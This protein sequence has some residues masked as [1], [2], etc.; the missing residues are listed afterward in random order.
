[1]K[2]LIREPLVH[3]LLLGAALFALDSALSRKAAS[4]ADEIVVSQGQ[5][6]NLTANFAKAWQRAPEPEELKTLVDEY[7][8]EEM[9]SREAIKL[10]LDRQDPV[11]RQRLQQKMEFLAED[12]SATVDPTDEELANYLE[13]NPERFQQDARFTFRQVYLDPDKRGT[14]IDAD[15]AAL[16]GRLRAGGARIEIDDLGD[17]L[18]LPREFIKEPRAAVSAQFGLEFANA[19]GRAPAGEWSGPIV[20]SFGQHLVWVSERSEPRLPPLEEVRSRVE[21]SLATARRQEAVQAFLKECLERYTVTVQWPESE[22]VAER[23]D[24]PE[25]MHP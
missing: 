6:E 25:A 9:L 22:P 20:S 1:M 16:L 24:Q 5:I 8:K 2:R 18:L 10:G 11:I 7:V 19:L 4:P 23:P 13:Q 12:L 3:F 15:A 17:R 21:R 14:N